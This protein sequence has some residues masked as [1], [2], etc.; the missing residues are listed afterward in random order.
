MAFLGFFVDL[1]PS[2]PELDSV[3]N[4][5]EYQGYLPGEGKKQPVRRADNL[6]HL[7]VPTVQKFWE[8]QIRGALRAC[9]GL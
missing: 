9:P 1:N 7:H 3:S 2:G 5:N 8:L 4:R 6:Y